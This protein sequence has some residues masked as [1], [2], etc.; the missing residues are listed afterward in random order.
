MDK[1]E[2]AILIAL[3]R[4]E[5]NQK[6]D[7]NRFERIEKNQEKMSQR[8]DVLERDRDIQ[9]GKTQGIMVIMSILGGLSLVLGI[10]S[11]IQNWL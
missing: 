9:K 1:G 6:H 2:T 8:I 3:E 10:I 7:S 5:A 11:T 4:I